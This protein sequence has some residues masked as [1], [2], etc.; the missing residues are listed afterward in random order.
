MGVWFGL[1]GSLV[2]RM[3]LFLVSVLSFLGCA[4]S[5]ESESM[6]TTVYDRRDHG[7]QSVGDDEV[8]GVSVV[9]ITYPAVYET[10]FWAVVVGGEGWTG[11]HALVS[12][13][14]DWTT[15]WKRRAGWLASFF[16]TLSFFFFWSGLC[17]ASAGI[18]VGIFWSLSCS[19][20]VLVF[21]VGF[22]LFWTCSLV[23]GLIMH[24]GPYPGWRRT[25][26]GS[27]MVGI[28]HKGGKGGMSLQAG[29]L[30]LPGRRGDTHSLYIRRDEV[31]NFEG[32][33]SCLVLSVSGYG[34]CGFAFLCFFFV[35]GVCFVWYNFRWDARCIDA[36]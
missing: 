29:I 23:C 3:G 27:F 11:Y 10:G 34:S 20:S 19:C 30:L 7:I 9:L 33:V 6:P 32:V 1:D 36:G 28:N 26:G 35:L 31:W 2:G 4:V 14:L 15:W 16:F 18:W 25:Q 13:L 5:S 22:V 8:A 24:L 17:I 12:C 21:F